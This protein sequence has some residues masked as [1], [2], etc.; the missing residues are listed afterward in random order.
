M[1]IPSLRPKGT[2]YRLFNETQRDRGIIRFSLLTIFFLILIN[3]HT[4]LLSTKEYNAIRRAL[5][6]GIATRN[7]FETVADI[8]NNVTIRD[9]YRQINHFVHGGDME[10]DVALYNLR[11]DVINTRHPRASG[12]LPDRVHQSIFDDGFER[13]YSGLRRTSA[14]FLSKIPGLLFKKPPAQLRG[15]MHL[16]AGSLICIYPVSQQATEPRARRAIKFINMFCTYWDDEMEFVQR[17]NDEYNRN[18]VLT[19]CNCRRLFETY[20]KE[21]NAMADLAA[22]GGII[23]DD[24]WL[25]LQTRCRYQE[26][27]AA[28]RRWNSW[29]IAHARQNWQP[30]RHLIERAGEL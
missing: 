22:G 8:G 20:T 13:F 10:M 26:V 15:G 17:N 9:R 3:H 24:R 1:I 11:T 25:F 16:D 6:L 2:A 4:D 28:A 30:M 21:I 23:H 19:L 5:S 29:A 18:I 7:T 12:P 27:L 14:E